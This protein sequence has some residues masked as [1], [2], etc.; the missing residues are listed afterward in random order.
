VA[1]AGHGMVRSPAGL[2]TLSGA[3]TTA[4][5]DLSAVDAFRSHWDGER[6]AMVDLGAKS[7]TIATVLDVVAT[8]L[9][10]ANRL[11]DAA[12]AAGPD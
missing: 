10:A 8:Q 9:E 7:A 1:G 12:Q 11:A 6:S 3:L 2:R 5:S 4:Q